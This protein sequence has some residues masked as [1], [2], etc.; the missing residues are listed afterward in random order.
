M[1]NFIKYGSMAALLQGLYSVVMH[2]LQSDLRFN[3]TL[4]FGIS[5][6][7][8]LLFMVM[9]VKAERND[10]EGLISFGEAL[11]TSFLTYLIY[12]IISLVIGYVLIGLYTPEDWD[13]MLEF[14]KNTTSSMLGAAGMDQVQIDTA[15][16]ELNVETLKEQTSG[17]GAMMISALTSS[18]LGLI[19]SLVISAIMKKNPTP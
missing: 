9:A 18:I 13:K 16:G 1:T 6:L 2:F 7:V 19:I 4:I 5:I 15:L 10:Q 12:I 8:P 3:G 11:K 14:Q 17:I